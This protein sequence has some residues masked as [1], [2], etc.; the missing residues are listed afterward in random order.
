[1]GEF[2]EML[3][4]FR[5]STGFTQAR[6]AQLVGLD[7]SYISR[8]ERGEREAP[9]REKVT[10]VASA[11]KLNADQ[12]SRLL[13]SAGYAPLIVERTSIA[14]PTL[15]LVADILGDSRVLPDEIELLRQYLRLLDSRR[16]ERNP[17]RRG[18]QA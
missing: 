7:P 13:L 8:I 2:G 16:T 10:E 5:R 12:A 11:L 1:M 17:Q 14:D 9:S 6:L 18:R 3:R 4:R 15:S